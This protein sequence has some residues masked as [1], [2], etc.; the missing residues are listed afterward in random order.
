MKLTFR[1]FTASESMRSLFVN[2]FCFR[3]CM[4]AFPRATSQHQWR[5]NLSLQCSTSHS[6]NSMWPTW[7]QFQPSTAARWKFYYLIKT[8]SILLQISLCFTRI[9]SKRQTTRVAPLG[10]YLICLMLQRQLPRFIVNLSFETGKGKAIQ[11]FTIRN[12]KF[13]IPMRS[14]LRNYDT[15]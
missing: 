12:R 3:V 2:S 8:K 13:D 5:T 1:Q 14:F 11:E 6:Q 7:S 9:R 4:C 15:F 10:G